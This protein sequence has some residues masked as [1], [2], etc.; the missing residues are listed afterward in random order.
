MQVVSNNLNTEVQVGSWND[1]MINYINKHQ[2]DLVLV[3]QKNI[4]S[5]LSSSKFNADFIV[6]K[7]NVPVITIP[8]RK[9]KPAPILFL[10]PLQIFAST[11]N[12]V[13][14]LYKCTASNATLQL[15][16]VKNR[17]PGDSEYY[18]TNHTGLYRKTAPYIQ[19]CKL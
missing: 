1:C 12:Y 7:T 13:R 14:Y 15:L 6:S 17:K 10:F 19:I 8:H 16:Q 5:V 2:I 18:C 4:L 9:K 3:G 11:E